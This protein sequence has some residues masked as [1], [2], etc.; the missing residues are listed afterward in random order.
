[1]FL[2]I[3]NQ[4]KI[5]YRWI[6]HIM[7]LILSNTQYSIRIFKWIH[8]VERTLKFN[9]I[10]YSNDKEVANIFENYILKELLYII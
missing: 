2:I 5:I 6:L 7:L 3:L 10:M 9:R 8:V 1:M 4:K